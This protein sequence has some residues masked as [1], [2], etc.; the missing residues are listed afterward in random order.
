MATIKWEF[1]DAGKGAAKVK[2]V[3][4]KQLPGDPLSSEGCRSESGPQAII[5]DFEAVREL[6]HHKGPNAMVE[7]THSF[8]PEESQKIGPE[9]VNKIG[10]EVA[11]EFFPGHQFVVVT[12]LDRDHYHNH[13]F[14]NSVSLETGKRI[15]NKIAKMKKIRGVN[16]RICKGYGL[17]IP[18]EERKE[19]AARMPSKVALMI[20]HGRRSFIADLMQKADFARAY[21]TSYA[22]YSGILAEFGVQA[23]VEKKNVTY[24]YPGRDVGIR[25]RS[26]GALYDKAGLEKSFKANDIRFQSD[27]KLRAKVASG[28]A[29]IRAEPDAIMAVSQ[30]LA[31]VTGGHFQSGV[32]DYSKHRIVPR[33]AARWAR[34]SE[35]ELAGCLVP[36]DEIRKAR[37][38]S[39]IAYCR[40]NGIDLVKNEKGVFSLKGRPFVEVNDYDWRNTKNNTRG[41]LIDLVA[42]HKKMTFLQAI[43]EI[44][45]NKKLLLLER[46]F[47]KV[48]RSYTS[49]YIPKAERAPIQSAL[50]ELSHLLARK[51]I[52]EEA[53][54]SLLGSGQ[55]Q[56]SDKGIIKVFAR[57][58]PGGAWEFA[59]GADGQW[60]RN[61]VGLFKNP[62]FVA[63][64]KGRQVTV[65]TDP[66]T[67]IRRRGVE[68][69][70]PKKG[71]HTVVGLMEPD[72]EVLDR[73]LSSRRSINT[74]HLVTTS[75]GKPSPAEVDFFNNLKRR[76]KD[77]GIDVQFISFE[78][79]LPTK[80]LGLEI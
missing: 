55:F 53:A 27:Q 26:L 8:T 24:F 76:Y 36:I 78:K 29:K 21:A 39:I 56:V 34:A 73:F 16:D 54:K 19:R 2:Y 63:D 22:E 69:L 7:L 50:T 51:G 15:H 79:A 42:A 77:L 6:H 44:N 10:H 71:S 52:K 25:G 43:A 48:G 20:R 9:L 30:D 75:P 66:F 49:F 68:P 28:I 13:I 1:L 12:H 38:H 67:F 40:Q 17:S 4:E 60:N 45:G 31:A 65:F 11:K 3:V 37:H 33:R 18:N 61:K 41:N 57:D 72:V 58:D 47:G 70:L 74:I 35:E 23:R 62:F 5:N 46:S 64:T 14:V 32:K 80:G 59:R